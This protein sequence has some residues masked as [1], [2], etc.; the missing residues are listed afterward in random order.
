MA[1]RPTSTGSEP[2]VSILMPFYNAQETIE[3]AVRS[4]L[5]QTY[6]NWELLLLD[7]GSTDRSRVLLDNLA[8]P[9]VVVRLDDERKGLAPRLNECIALARGRYLARMDSDDVSYPQR[10]RAQVDYLERHPEADVLGC[11][12]VVFG[13]DGAALGKRLVPEAHAE[14]VAN[15]A[16]GFGLAHPTWMARAEWFQA[17][18][19]DPG[20]VR[21]EDFE[22]LYRTHRNS[23]FANLPDLLYGY[24]EP[25]NGFRKRLKT[26]LGRI[27][28]FY[29]Q[30]DKEGSGIFWNATRRESWKIAADAMVVL[31]SQRYASLKSRTQALTATEN[32]EWQS[33]LSG[34]LQPMTHL[35]AA[36][37]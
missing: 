27:G 5:A 28:Y 15:P 10:L 9:R 20:A 32:A 11:S 19:Y 14:I 4:M 3:A 24:R 16:S 18:Q 35:T 25:H 1:F 29:N 23:S 8:D 21:Y 34:V 12:V 26:R 17:N 13:D 37:K 33:V 2:L 6:Q 31:T 22:L 7:D 36:G 30:R